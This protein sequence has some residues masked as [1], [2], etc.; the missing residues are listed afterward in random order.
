M[1]IDT[2]NLEEK[3]KRG[4]AALQAELGLETGGGLMLYAKRGEAFSVR[5]DGKT[6][7][8]TYAREAE[9][10]RGVMRLCQNSGANVSEPCKFDML[11]VMA[12]NSRNAVLRPE[13]V[14][15][16][17]RK[18]ALLGM[19][20]LMLYTEDT[21]E[22]EGEPYFG[23]L[24]GRFTQAEIKELD[25]YARDFGV[26]LVPCVQTLAHLNAAMRWAQYRGIVDFGDILLV[27]EERTY[28][29][30]ENMFRSLS[31]AFTSRKIHIGMDEAHML[32]LGRYLDKH[33]YHDR[34]DI[35]IMHIKRV[36][37]LAEKYGF[38]PM[39]WS[40]MFFR[41][42]FEGD[43]YSKDGLPAEMKA[44]IPKNVSMVYWDY[45]TT[46]KEAYD[47]NLKRHQDMGSRVA[48]A[49]GAWTWMGFT[50]QNGFSL[51]ANDAAISA[52]L[53]NGVR[54]LLLTMWGDDGAE[55][56][57]FSVMP[58]LTAAAQKAYGASD[59]KDVFSVVMGCAYD[60]FMRLDAANELGG[61]ADTTN[62]SK[63]MLYNDCFNGIFD[64]TVEGGEA[65][66]Y[67][68]HAEA[69]KEAGKRAGGWKYLFDTQEALC[70]VLADKYDLGI[71]TRA[72]YRAGDRKAAGALT[73]T[74][75][76]VIKNVRA[77]YEAFRAQWMRVNKP[78]GFDVQDQ[79]FG[80]LLLRLE[81][82]RQRL[83][84]FASGAIDRIEELDEEL[85]AF[86]EQV[87]GKKRLNFN[88]WKDTVSVNPI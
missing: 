63:Y 37:A 17:V 42:A 19:N 38:E 53:D 15:Q 21:Y 11:G 25:A 39:M 52:C 6:A 29:L 16:L 8:I 87:K 55:C 45:Y 54:D 40:D 67:L 74:Y 66:R 78:H 26:E 58:A 79:R 48:Y 20:T 47:R 83:A 62:P 36:V 72:A 5:S 30:I 84:S 22:V 88:V 61:E 60:D 81:H 65:E 49:G 51:R 12:D 56:P 85:L 4:L 23:Y 46:D 69:L 57:P 68:A 71:R 27:G 32:G 43:Y 14:R 77:L 9:F 41:L 80:G 7:T 86:A 44:I 13:S 70:R 2:R 34:A 82:C 59:T 76:T 35:M 73:G 18:L 75:D 1:R 31:R 64:S 10:Y 50:P 28:E 3:F 24:R 33:G